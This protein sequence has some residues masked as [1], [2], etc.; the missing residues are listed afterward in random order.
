LSW[1]IKGGPYDIDF[2]W[3]YNASTAL[4]TDETADIN[5]STADDVALPPIQAT[6]E[7]DA[8]YIGRSKIF[9]EIF[10]SVTTPGAYNDITIAWEY[11]NGSAWVP[12]PNVSDGTYGFTSLFGTVSWDMPSDWKKRSVNGKNYYWVRARAVFGATPSITTAPLAGEA[13]LYTKI[14]LPRNPAKASVK[15][16][17]VRKSIPMPG[18]YPTIISHGKQPK[19]LTITGLIAER[20]K[21]SSDLEFLYLKPLSD[22]VYEKVALAAPGTRYDGSYI[23]TSFVFDE[24]GGSPSSF[25][26][27]MEFYYGSEFIVL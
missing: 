8:L 24:K 1:A 7:G 18:D 6:A 11:Y 19:V 16:T 10:I 4:Y 3:S 17:S 15:Y 21:D 22:F 5:E 23:V 13:D 27:K 2:A 14:T 25:R 12:L 26:F 20:G 9:N